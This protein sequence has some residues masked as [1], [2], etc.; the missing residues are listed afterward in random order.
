MYRTSWST[1]LSRLR[2]LLVAALFGL[3]AC[4]FEPLYGEQDNGAATEDLMSRV[5][6]PPIAD[7][8][9]QLVRIELTNRL[10]PR[11]AQEPLYVVSVEVSEARQGLAVRRDDSATRANLILNAQFVLSRTSGGDPLLSGEI[12]STNGFDILVSDFAT[13]AAKKDARRRGARDIA[14]GIVDRLSLFL[15]R[16]NISATAP[17]QR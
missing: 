3:S 10:T 5:F 9:G 6:V 7:R 2:I 14:D 12:R 11:P 1:S 17:A 16:Q 13:L 8:L 15:S 4:G